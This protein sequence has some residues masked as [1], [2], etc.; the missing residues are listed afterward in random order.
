MRALAVLLSIFL[1]A[2]LPSFAGSKGDVKRG[3]RVFA[4]MQCAIC[5]TDGGN[6]LNPERPLKGPKFLKRIP[7][8]KTL[9]L[10][11]RQGITT[12][13]MPAF[14]KDKLSDQDLADVM[15]YIRSLSPAVPKSKKPR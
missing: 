9:E 7:D 4:D 5:H 12:K 10:T 8:D 15:V 3:K 13:G 2:A 1:L 6:N 11:I 14:A